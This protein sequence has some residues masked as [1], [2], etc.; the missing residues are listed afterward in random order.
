LEV[1]PGR[2]QD[3]AAVRAVHER[4]FAPSATEADLVDALRGSGDDVPELWLVAEEDGEVVGH[5]AFSLARLDGGAEVLALV[6]VLGHPAY[7][8]RFGVEPA[9]VARAVDECPSEGS[10]HRSSQTEAH[11]L[12]Y[13]PTQLPTPQVTANALGAG[14]RAVGATLYAGAAALKIALARPD[15]VQMT[16]SR[17]GPTP[18]SAIGTPTKSEM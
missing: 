11:S 14:R 13:R 18:T 5:I 7:Y 6:I 12:P 3:A 8:P 16:S 15:S 2:A 17:P 10:I 9:A 4:A 1:R